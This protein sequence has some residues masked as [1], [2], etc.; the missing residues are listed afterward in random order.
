MKRTKLIEI[1]K[2]VASEANDSVR[3]KNGNK[4]CRFKLNPDADTLPPQ[5]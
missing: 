5:R 2:E 4:K 1:V 3:K